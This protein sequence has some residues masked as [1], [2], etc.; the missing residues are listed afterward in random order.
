MKQSNSKPVKRNLT[1]SAGV[2]VKSGVKKP[3]KA[4][5]AE[6][7]AI[8]AW[9]LIAPIDAS[10]EFRPPMRT[11]KPG[12]R[13]LDFA[14]QSNYATLPQGGSTQLN[15][16]LRAEI[17][18][19]E[20]SM[21]LAENHYIGVINTALN[22]DIA[23]HYFTELYGIARAGL[24]VM[25]RLAGQEPPIPATWEEVKAQKSLAI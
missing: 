9:Q 14:V 5:K 16:H 21:L 19:P 7:L 24:Q 17:F 10:L 15:L 2:A 23:H 25:L 12:E 20:G 1:K 11:P 3:E 8:S 18:L 22:D 6:K 13:S 4:I